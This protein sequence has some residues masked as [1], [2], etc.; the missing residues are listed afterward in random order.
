[1]FLKRDTQEE[2]DSETFANLQILDDNDIQQIDRPPL[3]Y[4]VPDGLLEFNEFDLNAKK[5]NYSYSVNE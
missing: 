5:I 1:M 3:N 2:A 4:L